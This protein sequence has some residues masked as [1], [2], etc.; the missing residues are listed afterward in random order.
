M[1]LIIIDTFLLQE[2]EKIE[3]KPKNAKKNHNNKKCFI[4]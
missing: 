3:D 1:P 2:V 4:Y